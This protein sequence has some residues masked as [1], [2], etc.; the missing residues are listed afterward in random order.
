MRYD[1]DLLKVDKTVLKFWYLVQS[2]L[3]PKTHIFYEEVNAFCSRALSCYSPISQGFPEEFPA[4]TSWLQS[5]QFLHGKGATHFFNGIGGHG[6][7]NLADISMSPAEWIGSHNFAGLSARAISA[8]SPIP[9]VINGVKIDDVC[10]MFFQLKGTDAVSLKRQGVV[11][12]LLA[13]ASDAM[14]I[15]PGL[16]VSQQANGI[17]GLKDPPVMLADEVKELLVKSDTEVLAHLKSR[18]FNTQALEV[19]LTSMDDKVSRPVAVFYGVSQGGWQ[20]VQDLYEKLRVINVCEACLLSQKTNECSYK[21]E[22]CWT[23]KRVCDACLNTGFKEWHPAARPCSTC[24][25]KDQIC[26]RIIQLGWC[27]DCESR[28]KAFMERLVSLYPETFQFPM[29]DPPHNL[30]SVRSARFWYWLFLDESLINLRIILALRR[31]RNS[32]ISSPVKKAVSLKALK[33]KDR[34]SVETALEVFTPSLQRVL[35]KEDVVL[36]IVP[37]IYTF[38]RQN[39]PNTVICPVDVVI[40]QETGTVFFSDYQLNQVMSCDLHC[41]ATLTSVAG[42]SQSGCRDGKKS[43]FCE[44]SGLCL[45][46]NLIF[47]CDSGNAAIRVID[48][49]RLVSRKKNAA[50]LDDSSN[51]SQE[52]EDNIPIVEKYSVTSTLGL[53]STSQT[54]LMR[55]FSICCGRKILQEYPDLYVGDT[56]QGKIFKVTDVKVQNQCSARLRE[57]YPANGTE[58]GVVPVALA[59]SKERLFVANGTRNEAGI[60]VLHANL[61]TLLYTIAS[62]LISSPSGMCLVN[63]CLLLS[64][65]N[66][67]IVKVSHVDNNAIVELFSGKV[68]DP[69]NEDGVVSS[70]RFYSPHGIANMG[71]SLFICDSGNKAIRLVTNVEPFRKLSSLLYPY[72]QVF[73]IDHYRGAP[74]FSFPTAMSV[75]DRWVEF[76]M[77]W[78]Y[79]TRERTGRTSTQGPDQVLPYATRRSFEM[80]HSSLTRLQ[81]LLAELGAEDLIDEVRLSALVT[82]MVENFFSIMRQD[83]PM[84]TQLEYGIRR[85]ACVRELEKKMYRGHFH[86]FTGP[87]SYYPNKV[88]NSAPPPKPPVSLVEDGIARLTLDETRELRDFAT[89]LGRSVRQHSVRDKS[90]EDTGHLP[91]AISF[92]LQQREPGCNVATRILMEGQNA[93]HQQ[94]REPPLNR[95]LRQCEVFFEAEE[96]VAV[97]HN[98]RREQWG[99]FLAL[100]LKDLLVKDKTGNELQFTDHVMDILW[101]DN[102]NTGDKFIFSEAYRDNRN[103]PYA[104]VDRVRI[105]EVIADAAGLKSYKLPQEEADRIERLLK[106]GADSDIDSDEDLVETERVTDEKSSGELPRR[107]PV[108]TRSGRTATRLRL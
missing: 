93:R 34:M 32:M 101:L 59:F 56:K 108:S 46:K 20:V 61:G 60:I 102:S 37:E 22:D 57:L 47:V 31:D 28:Q 48:I 84:P 23:N 15:K 70:A 58:T 68:N 88:M 2:G 52:Q 89:S 9:H 7:G 62:P 44:P 13:T 30:K 98:R 14:A 12:F 41:P 106:G 100:L 67:T 35:P 104:I 63:N 17:I 24:H 71:R 6:Q 4:L 90:K 21:C 45:Y 103:S 29:P 55:P 16:Q 81:N 11:G 91:Y 77:S 33:N 26:Y 5:N 95:S 36:T 107:V 42:D 10:Q 50:T 39:R 25:E 27:S 8:M 18:K 65:G 96:I 105:D 97:K 38:W 94:D 1:I 53:I 83:D 75:I 79:Q 49:A 66:H 87:K 99:F 3:L 43:L 64:C 85:A 51:E 54:P 92:S 74:R 73:D 76:L 19:H 40:H 78:G 72:A 82:L 80:M 86:Y 69:G